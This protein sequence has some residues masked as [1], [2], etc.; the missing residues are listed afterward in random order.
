MLIKYESR[1]CQ[2]VAYFSSEMFSETCFSSLFNCNSRSFVTSQPPCCF[3]CQNGWACITSPTSRSVYWSRAVRC[4]L[5]VATFFI[6]WAKT[7]ATVLSLCFLYS[8]STKFKSI[9]LST[10]LTAQ[11][12][13]KTIFPAMKWLLQTQIIPNNLLVDLC[14]V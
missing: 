11:F 12:Y 5:V 10:A 1:F 6:F 9:C 2:C 13:E 3:P 4:I 8:C 7:N 14:F